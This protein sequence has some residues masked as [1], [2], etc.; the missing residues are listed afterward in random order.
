MNL[1]NNLLEQEDFNNIKQL[2]TSN[3]FAWFRQKGVASLTDDE[4]ADCYFTHLFYDNNEINSAFF[5]DLKPLLDKLKIK[6]LLKVKANFYPKTEKVIEHDF[7]TD[8][9]FTHK[10][11]IL[12]INTNNGYTKFKDG[13]KADS[14][15][16]RSVEFDGSEKHKSTTCSDKFARINLGINYIK[17]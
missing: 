17:Q 14:I 4:T 5:N 8:Y 10:A 2:L 6:K 15:E 12:S 9:P 7:H 3:N 16:N 11:I 13:T 1:K